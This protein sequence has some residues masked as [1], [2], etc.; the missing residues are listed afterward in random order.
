MNLIIKK[1]SNQIENA[2]LFAHSEVNIQLQ[3][4]IAASMARLCRKGAGTKEVG[5]EHWS[6]RIT[7]DSLKITPTGPS[8]AGCE[9]NIFA[10]ERCANV[11]RLPPGLATTMQ[12]ALS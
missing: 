12:W 3:M 11:E 10:I 4:Q 2:P 6:M 5:P 8:P 9:K 7:K 1:T